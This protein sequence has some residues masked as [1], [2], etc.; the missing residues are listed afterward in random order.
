[1]RKRWHVTWLCDCHAMAPQYCFGDPIVGF[2]FSSGIYSF[3]G[4][5]RTLTM[6]G[7]SF[8]GGPRETGSVLVGCHRKK[9][10]LVCEQQCFPRVWRKPYVPIKRRIKLHHHRFVVRDFASSVLGS[11]CAVVF[12]LVTFSS[13]AETWLL[14]VFWI[15]YIKAPLK[16]NCVE[17][18]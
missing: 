8:C 5:Q 12:L 9:G 11:L 3:I 18:S 10:L 7:L 17:L 6:R 13:P 2:W 1:M 4:C 16:K 15:R 14:S